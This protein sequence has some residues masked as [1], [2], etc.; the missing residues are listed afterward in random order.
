MGHMPAVTYTT[1]SAT[2]TPLRSG[3]RE[4]IRPLPSSRSSLGAARKDQTSSP[5]CASRQYSQPSSEATKSLPACTA[6]ANRIGPPA[7]KAH[8]RLP[9]SSRSARTVS[10]ADDPKKT[11]P[12]ATTGWNA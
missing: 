6:G 7:V 10:S 4:I 11:S 8:A 9:L 1:P 5:V 3:Q 2:R 12:S